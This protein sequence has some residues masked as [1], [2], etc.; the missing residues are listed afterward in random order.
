MSSLRTACSK[1]AGPSLLVR[2]KSPPSRIMS[3]RIAASQ[4]WD[5][6]GCWAVVTRPARRTRAGR[7]S[8]GRRRRGHP[9]DARVH[10]L[11]PRG[12]LTGAVSDVADDLH[13]D[14]RD[15]VPAQQR[16]HRR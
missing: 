3:T 6:N 4:V 15:S 11:I 12:F 9:G 1:R 10:R 16:A 7:G 2:V 8:A 5:L 13:V 14:I